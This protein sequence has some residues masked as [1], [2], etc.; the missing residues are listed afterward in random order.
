MS[1]ARLHGGPYDGEEIEP[2]GVEY[3]ASQ[4]HAFLFIDDVDRPK[5]DVHRYKRS[6]RTPGGVWLYT[7]C[8]RVQGTVR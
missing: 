2:P 4:P 1:T 7:H 5:L 3:F 6:G 8:G